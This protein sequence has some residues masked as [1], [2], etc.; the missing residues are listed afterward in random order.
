MLK[1]IPSRLSLSRNFIEPA[2]FFPSAL[3]TFFRH[4]VL[5]IMVDIL[6]ALLQNYRFC[7]LC[8]IL[9]IQLTEVHLLFDAVVRHARVNCL[10]SFLFTN[11]VFREFKGRLHD[12]ILYE[13]HFPC[14][15]DACKLC[16]SCV[17]ANIPSSNDWGFAL[18][19]LWNALL[20]IIF[21][22]TA[23]S[24]LSS[25]PLHFKCS[26]FSNRSIA[27]AK[28]STTSNYQYTHGFLK[29]AL[30]YSDQS[31]HFET[32]H[33]SPLN[34]IKQCYLQ[35]FVGFKKATP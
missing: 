24:S 7:S 6:S 4:V 17:C 3:R 11:P 18:L 12:Y 34:T 15:F 2:V 23:S 10:F 26:S 33:D 14:T 27:H 16:N 1:E 30:F 5:S 25:Y 32:I 22:K 13:F 19:P 20:S 21:V 31:H 35:Q 8:M 28:L 9:Y 29:A